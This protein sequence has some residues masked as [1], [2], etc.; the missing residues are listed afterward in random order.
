M[1]N[2][3]K[4]KDLSPV[5]LSHHGKECYS[6]SL[7]SV[8]KALSNI[9]EEYKKNS[10]KTRL[11]TFL[12]EILDLNY[13][14]YSEEVYQSLNPQ[15]K[16]LAN[17]I[18]FKEFFSEYVKNLGINLN[19]IRL[20]PETKFNTRPMISKEEFESLA[21]RYRGVFMPYNSTHYVLR[22]HSAPMQIFSVNKKD[23]SKLIDSLDYARVLMPVV[24]TTK[25]SEN[26]SEA[27]ET[28]KEPDF[29]PNSISAHF[30]E[31]TQINA[32]QQLHK[33]FK[34]IVNMTQIYT[35]YNLLYNN[36]A[37]DI[38]NEYQ[39]EL[40]GKNRYLNAQKAINDA[41]GEITGLQTLS[42]NA[43]ESERDGINVLI[44]IAKENYANVRKQIIADVQSRVK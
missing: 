26:T 6:M 21:G 34:E 23:R 20:Q 17:G 8:T 3:R 7:S 18:F 4:L 40:T 33:I 32:V 12:N 36:G 11:V 15:N 13:R 9:P 29:V 16:V 19:D 41:K 24:Y 5:M 28:I 14:A 2:A 37:N 35:R 22:N 30:V 27:N 25:W 1:S 38:Y 39:N 44:E 43:A 10:L 42:D 31:D